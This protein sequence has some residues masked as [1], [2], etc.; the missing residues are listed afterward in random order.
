MAKSKYESIVKDKLIL[1]EAWARNGLTIEQIAKNLGISKVTLYKYMN[2]HTELSEH[3]KKGKE[4]VDI[5]VENALLK[6][7]L[8]YKY[9]EVTKELFKDKETGEE[10]LKVTKVVTKEVAPDTTAQ[11][12]WL[13]NRKPEDWRD[14]KD[15]EHSG[16]LNNPYEGLTKEQLLKIASEDDG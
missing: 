2:E 11:I 8:G 9:N 5:E 13:K 10:E 4:V 1:I 16:N 3:L 12:F 15:I 14:K 6:R 7:A